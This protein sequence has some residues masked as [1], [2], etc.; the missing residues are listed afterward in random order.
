[1][2][3]NIAA[4]NRAQLKILMETPNLVTQVVSQLGYTNDW[5]IRK[6]AAWVVSNIVTSSEGI[7][8]IPYI[9]QLVQL[10]VVKSLCDLLDVS[11]TRIVI[12]ALEAI[13]QL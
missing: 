4:G 8:N 2:L 3:S 12:V 9:S 13:S 11:D 5:E 1:M 6:E 7:D 10:G